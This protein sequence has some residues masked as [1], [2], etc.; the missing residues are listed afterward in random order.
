M[1]L[2]GQADGS[3]KSSPPPPSGRT[4]PR[5]TAQETR[6]IGRSGVTGS[7]AVPGQRCDSGAVVRRSEGVGL[8]ES[9]ALFIDEQSWQAEDEASVLITRAGS[10]SQSAFGRLAA[11]ATLRRACAQV[12]AASRCLP[13]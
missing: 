13:A 6:H 1:L 5:T 12:A 9:D 3:G 4:E 8:D 2:V 7:R 11:G 10:L